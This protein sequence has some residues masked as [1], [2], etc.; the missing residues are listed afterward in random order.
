MSFLMVQPL[1]ISMYQVKDCLLIFLPAFIFVVFNARVQFMLSC[2]QNH[3]NFI[4]KRHKDLILC[5][6]VCLC[7]Q[8]HS[9]LSL[10][11]VQNFHF[12][13]SPIF[14]TVDHLGVHTHTHPLFLKKIIQHCVNRGRSRYSWYGR[15][16]QHDM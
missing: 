4:L 3:R 7:F 5:P 16:W 14:P 6:S 8:P 12:P 9:V 13:H 10:T 15:V 2:L 11:L 1:E